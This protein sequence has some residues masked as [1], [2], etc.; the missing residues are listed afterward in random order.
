MTWYAYFMY[1][2]MPWATWKFVEWKGAV[3]VSKASE[4]SDFVVGLV[5]FDLFLVFWDKVSVGLDF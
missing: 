1:L 2:Y 3:N 5:R 4:H